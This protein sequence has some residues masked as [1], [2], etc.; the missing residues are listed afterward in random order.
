MFAQDEGSCIC[1]NICLDNVGVAAGDSIAFL[2]G[3]SA[4]ASSHAEE[5][6]KELRVRI[7]A[8]WKALRKL[9]DAAGKAE[10]E[11]RDPERRPLPADMFMPAAGDGGEEATLGQQSMRTGSGYQDVV[12]DDVI[13]WDFAA[14]VRNRSRTPLRRRVAAQAETVTTRATLAKGAPR[15]GG[16]KQASWGATSFPALRAAEADWPRGASEDQHPPDSPN[17]QPE[18]RQAKKPTPAA[19]P[20]TLQYSDQHQTYS[21]W[22]PVTDESLWETPPI[23]GE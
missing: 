7:G 14:T 21:Y 19:R 12:A 23:T 11:A 17:A 20:W 10:A 22:N 15:D 6:Q 5:Y 8:F 16:W 13:K 4:K 18:R 1:S 3:G 2:D 9:D